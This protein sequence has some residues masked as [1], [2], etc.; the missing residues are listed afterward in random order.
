MPAIIQVLLN[1]TAT[2]NEKLKRRP[3]TADPDRFHTYPVIK[4][5]FA[6]LII[7][8]LKYV[9]KKRNLETKTNQHTF[10]VMRIVEVKITFFYQYR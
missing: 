3:S 9:I 1:K 4:I 2:G 8:L 10:L 7:F 6:N 5:F